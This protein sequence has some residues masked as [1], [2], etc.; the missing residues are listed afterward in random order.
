MVFTAGSLHTQFGVYKWDTELLRERS[1]GGFWWRANTA[2]T[3]LRG[4]ASRRKYTHS[5]DTGGYMSI[6]QPSSMSIE[7]YTLHSSLLNS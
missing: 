3:S 2:V 5:N 1:G 7:L 6:A 4:I